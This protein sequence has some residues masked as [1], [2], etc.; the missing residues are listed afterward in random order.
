MTAHYPDIAEKARAVQ[1]SGFELR[2]PYRQGFYRI[3]FKRTLD[4]LAVVATAFVTLPLIA[5]MAVVVS[6][7]GHSP[8]YS[9]KRLGQGGRIFTLWK[10][11]SMVPNADERLE[12][13]LAQNPAA[14]EEWDHT[15][16]LR[17]DPRITRMGRILRKC[18]A[19]ELPQLWNVL[20]GD[21][22]LVGPRPMMP[23]QAS[24][25]PGTAYYAL[26]PGITGSWQ[27]SARNDCSF[28]ER[29]R[30][31]NDYDR[32]VSLGLDLSILLAT[33]RVVIRA[34]GH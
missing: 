23:E 7:D 10:L 14:R 29:A 34:T 11:R 19:D 6:L 9:Q 5:L 3:G 17:D 21:M 26:R 13:H 1:V 18:S 4:V 32:H 8:F 12:A 33:V 20:K 25:Y 28:A 15:Q 30:F 31:D 2:H 22:S 27:V 24:L 16:K